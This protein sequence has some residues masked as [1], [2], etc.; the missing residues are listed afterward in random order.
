MLP[1]WSS[2]TKKCCLP[3]GLALLSL[4]L[5]LSP[6]RWPTIALTRSG[7]PVA[8]LLNVLLAQVHC[9]PCAAPP[10]ARSASLAT[11]AALRLRSCCSS[12]DS[13]R[14]RFGGE[15]LFEMLNNNPPLAYRG[16][17]LSPAAGHQPRIARGLLSRSLFSSLSSYT[18]SSTSSSCPRSSRLPSSL[19]WQLMLRRGGGCVDARRGR[20]HGSRLPP[21]VPLLVPALAPAMRTLADRPGVSI[22]SVPVVVRPRC[23]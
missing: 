14:S 23:L 11:W 15:N 7:R 9:R 10:A 3:I 22:W 13:L 18:Y 2:T 4:F 21:P 19:V 16:V 1:S 5:S 20:G 8:P 12:S 6:P 17:S